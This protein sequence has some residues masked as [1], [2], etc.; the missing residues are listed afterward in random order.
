MNLLESGAK[1]KELKREREESDLDRVNQNGIQVDGNSNEEIKIPEAIF[2]SY[3]PCLKY[4]DHDHSFPM[5]QP[6][7]ESVPQSILLR[8]Q[9]KGPRDH[10]NFLIPNIQLSSSINHHHHHH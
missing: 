7:P 2:K 8:C 4:N 1:A 5:N 9:K 6:S 10:L 3:C